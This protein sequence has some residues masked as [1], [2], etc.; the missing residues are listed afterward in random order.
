MIL[1]NICANNPPI[2]IL[3]AL[4]IFW[5]LNDYS[6]LPPTE[7]NLILQR[8]TNYNSTQTGGII[9]KTSERRPSRLTVLLRS[10]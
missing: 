9:W 3:K 5:D 7:K 4:T 2:V 1:P 6:P 8:L 10:I